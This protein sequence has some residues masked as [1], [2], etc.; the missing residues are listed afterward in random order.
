MSVALRLACVPWRSAGV[1][2]LSGGL[3]VLSFAPFGLYPVAVLALA[4][5]YE[6]IHGREPR[7][8]FGLGWLF[9]LGLF[10]FGVA[11]IRISLNEFG[12]MPALAAN[13][14]MLLMVAVLALYCAAA[15]AL[16]RWLEGL[17]G[18]ASGWFGPVLIF[19]SLWLLVEWVRGW[20]FTGFPWLY[21]GS[22]QLDGPL[23]GLAPVLGT[24]GLNLAVALSAGLLWVL[25]RRPG[26]MRRRAAIAL[27]T[28]WLASAALWPVDWTQP[29]SDEEGRPLNV[30]VIQGNIPQ[31]MKWAPDGLLPTID[32]YLRLTKAHLDSDLIVWPETAIPAFRHEVEDALI[33]PLGETAREA[34]TEVVLG[35]PVMEANQRYY[36]GLVSVGRAE[37]QYFKRHLVPFGEY[38]PFKRQLRPLIDWFEVPMSDF[39]H[40]KA[41]RPLLQVGRVQVGASICYEDV[42]A[43]EVRQAL[44]EAAYLINVSNDAWF[45]DSLAPHQHLQLARL[46]ALEAGRWMVRATNT[47][48]SAIID[49][50]GRVRAQSPLFER[51]ALTGTI[52]ARV[53]AT[54][55]VRF[56]SLV[57]LAMAVLMLAAG[58][59]LRARCFGRQGGAEAVRRAT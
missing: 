3:A 57:P 7:T 15:A 51:L 48:I 33:Q 41:E 36:N 9:G 5:L 55:F 35:V 2:V 37:D 25:L 11:W 24:H 1:A 19:P 49:P 50:R 34:G 31:S 23:G 21:L 30:A 28:I 38:L 10:G 45:G 18:A 42:F 20:L 40:G 13:T 39:S 26:R 53:G 29:A 52:Q 32:I 46:R 58:L 43:E 22:G 8:A 44:P 27:A 56:G 59:L 17:G 47:G 14:L 6:A 54:P 12:N 4:G 16:T